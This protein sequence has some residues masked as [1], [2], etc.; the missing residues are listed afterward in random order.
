[1]LDRLKRRIRT[2]PVGPLAARIYRMCFPDHRDAR[3]SL[4][5]RYDRE[6]GEVMRRVLARDSCGIDV[7]AHQG[8][9]LRQMIEIAPAG[10]H[11][12]FEPLPHLAARLREAFPGVRVHET[13][14][15]ARRGA[16]AFVYVENAPAYSGLKRRIYDRPD[17]VLKWCFPSRT[18]PLS[19]LLMRWQAARRLRRRHA[20]WAGPSFSTATRYPRRNWRT[21]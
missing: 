5:A 8:T 16:A 3:V 17:P 14:L 6:A 1:M 21:P 2:S 4:N 7:G 19:S 18:K 13:A 15:G 9:I 10:T 11:F 20:P 12:A